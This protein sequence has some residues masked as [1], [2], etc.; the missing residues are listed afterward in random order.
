MVIYECWGGHW[1]D[2]T[3]LWAQIAAVNDGSNAKLR[4]I[5]SGAR[6]DYAKVKTMPRCLSKKSDFYWGGKTLAAACLVRF[7]HTWQFDN[8][9]F[10]QGSY[11]Y[12]YFKGVCV[13]CYLWLYTG[14]YFNRELGFV[15]GMPER[16]IQPLCPQQ[17][18]Q[19]QQEEW[20]QQEDPP[21]TSSAWICLWLAFIL[22]LEEWVSGGTGWILTPSQSAMTANNT[23][24]SSNTLAIH[25]AN[26]LSFHFFHSSALDHYHPLLQFFL[27]LYIL[28]GEKPKQN[29]FQT[30]GLPQCKTYLFHALFLSK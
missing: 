1:R 10:V 30:H 14:N 28:R 19:S 22:L 25:S 6:W 9:V 7:W 17:S 29:S 5:P 20:S 26:F 12:I 3:L 21:P 8:E 2:L 27:V 11:Q 23:T 16:K 4:Q 13:V 15:R 18:S 24:D